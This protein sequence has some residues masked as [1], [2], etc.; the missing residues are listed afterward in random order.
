M[1][2][3]PI[4]KQDKVTRSQFKKEK[5]GEIKNAKPSEEQKAL[6]VEITKNLDLK[7]FDLIKE[8]FG[9][10]FFLRNLSKS[11]QKETIK[12]MT[13][14]SIDAGKVLFEQG[15]TGKFFYVVSQGSFILEIDGKE[16]KSIGRGDSFGDLAL[17]HDDAR[18]GTITAEKDS[19]IWCLSR[20]NFQ[21]I[22]D[23]YNKNNIKDSETFINSIGML[24]TAT[25]DIK[26]LISAKVVKESFEKGDFIFKEGD[27]ANCLYLVSEG[28]VDCVKDDKVLRTLK[29][30]ESMGLMGA[31]S[32]GLRTLSCI[33]GEES[34]L[35]SI[36]FESLKNIIGDNFKEVL[37]RQYIMYYLML[38]PLF[39]SMNK[40]VVD[41]I[42]DNLSIEWHAAGEAIVQVGESV[43]DR[44]IFVIEGAICSSKNSKE[45][46]S[47]GEILF[48][49][50]LVA[51]KG[52]KVECDHIAFPD[53]LVA[54]ITREQIDELGGKLGKASRRNSVDS[55]ES[56]LE[57]V[58]L[59]K[60]LSSNKFKELTK[61]VEKIVYHQGEKII[62]QGEAGNSMF[63]V[64]EGEVEVDI[65]GKYVRTLTNGSYF[66]ERSLFMN[67]P[68]SATI[69]CKTDS[70]VYVLDKDILEK[71][72]DLEQIEF[73][74]E[75][76][77]LQDISV[78]LERLNL[79]KRLGEGSYG[80]VF[81][82]VNV[83]TKFVYA[84]KMISV[85]Q[86]N[87]ENLHE[88]IDLERKLLLQVDHPF[89]VKLVKTM[90][91]DNYIYFL[92]EHI[93]G[94]D[95]F[96]AIRV[97]GLLDKGQTQFYGAS[98]LLMAKYLRE[99]NIIFRDFKPENVMVAAN[100][101]CKL[102]DFGT[103]TQCADRTFTIIGTPHYMAPEMLLGKGYSFSSDM[104]SIG[105]CMYEFLCGN[106]PF[107][108]SVTEPTKVYSAVLNE[109]LKYPKFVKDEK[110]RH[111]IRKMLTKNQVNRLIRYED[112]IEH[113]WFDDFSI[114]KLEEF[115][116]KPPYKPKL[117]DT[118]KKTL[119]TTVDKIA[120]SDIFKE[121]LEGA[122]AK[123][124]ERYRERF[125]KWYEAF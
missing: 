42:I 117:T 121:N 119:D 14:C 68:R 118:P 38:N 69:R 93:Q 58:R 108:E 6:T 59:F 37:L 78:T 70:V 16:I 103:A 91:R 83:D 122:D 4:S 15:T 114:V 18:S 88:N 39:S 40:K 44:I 13:L 110:F 54:T 87:L 26:R 19:K 53:C 115:K 73:F 3:L 65:D 52:A 81:E 116:S 57:N 25:D 47:K 41:S 5:I 36:S 67:E 30:G 29:K 32:E 64:G 51:N 9:H 45:T 86:V 112:I 74:T 21:K 100:G 109:E 84:L 22:V 8:C 82:A 77:H 113:P 125:A 7:D 90:K 123:K 99:K 56:S 105:V 107:A 92:M 95:L 85:D 72:F 20:N 33:S 46:C 97:I 62:N 102:I 76:L 104:W 1:S 48:F 89:I 60:M 111:L 50:E 11:V 17:L 55:R 43:G 94:E 101:F 75:R 35:Y 27:R 71:I 31:L 106:L 120:H 61:V 34:V 79:K 124:I 96:T 80:K 63:F 12:N 2:V 23:Y 66:G 49:N 24:S 98:L 28:S 10:N